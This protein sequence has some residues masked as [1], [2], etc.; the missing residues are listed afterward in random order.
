MADSDDSPRIKLVA[1]CVR[2][3]EPVGASDGRDQSLCANCFSASGDGESPVLADEDVPGH[4]KILEQIPTC[5]HGKAFIVHDTHME[6]RLLLRFVTIGVARLTGGLPI[7]TVANLLVV[8][9]HPH[10]T[11]VYDW[12]NHNS[13]NYLILDPPA[14][15]NIETII[16]NEGFLD[17]PR[18]IDIFIQVCEALEELHKINVVHGHIRPRSIGLLEQSN[19]V[20]TVKVTNFSITTVSSNDTEQ[21]LKVSRNYTCNDIFYMSPEELRGEFPSISSDIYSLG[22]VIFHS[23]TGKP[24]FRG[25]TVDEVR[26]LHLD[27]KPAEFKRRY[28]IPA[29]VEQVVLKMLETDPALRYKSIKGVRRDLERLRDNRAP[30][31][32]DKWKTWMTFLG[33]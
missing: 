33:Q 23:I 27:P 9:N 30:L 25:R 12:K 31:L 6:A 21:P 32:E 14:P 19:A 18:A 28:E 7:E 4:Y 10:L 1:T 20:D 2:C 5:V 17:L 16:Q 22:C 24:V 15:K 3:G 11:T 13:K 29:H 26:N 8:Q